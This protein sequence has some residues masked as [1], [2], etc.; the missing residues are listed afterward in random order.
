MIP[1]STS[2]ISAPQRYDV[3]GLLFAD[4]NRLL[5][6]SIDASQAGGVIGQHLPIRSTGPTRFFGVPIRTALASLTRPQHDAGPHDVI[7]G[8]INL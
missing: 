7:G 8:V 6:V 2:E 4:G 3:A 5:S 1:A